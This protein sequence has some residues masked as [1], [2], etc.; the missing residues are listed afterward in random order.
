MKKILI[1]TLSCDVPPYDKMMYTAQRTWDTVKADGMDTIYYC[2]GSTYK[3]NTENTIFLPV[4]ESLHTMGE[5]LLLAFE[6]ALQ[7]KDFDY[8]AR[9]HSCIYVDKKE[10]RKYVDSL[11]DNDVISG[12][13]V[14]GDPVWLWGGCGFVLSKDVVQKIVAN[15]HGWD[16]TKMEDMALS[17]ICSALQI[18]FTQGRGCSIDKKSEGVWSCTSYGTPGFDFENFEEMKKA[19]Q[20]FIRCKQDGARHVDEIIMK[21]LFKH[22]Q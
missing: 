14:L 2:G 13:Q 11:P 7:N 1:L 6:W 19:G 18:P 12:L 10:L 4:R 15:K 9:P 17:M 5:K 22:L 3:E 16:H 21:E 8:I 20:Y